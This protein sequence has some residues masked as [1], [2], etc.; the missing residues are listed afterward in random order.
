MYVH[1][2]I[3]PRYFIL[4]ESV[5]VTQAC[6][7][8]IVNPSP[9]VLLPKAIIFFIKP[10]TLMLI[11]VLVYGSLEYTTWST[12]PSLVTRIVSYK[13][14]TGAD[15]GGCT[16]CSLILSPKFSK[17][18]NTAWY[19]QDAMKGLPWSAGNYMCVNKLSVLH[20]NIFLLKTIDFVCL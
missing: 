3:W 10:R 9:N 19:F 5:G 2:K 1:I 7:N 16:G 18:K 15:P 17:E 13:I 8:T 12:R 20:T 6:P 4:W 11:Q 14:I